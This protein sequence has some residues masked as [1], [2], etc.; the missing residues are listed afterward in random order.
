M[1]QLTDLHSIPYVAPR[2]IIPS[3]TNIFFRLKERKHFADLHTTSAFFPHTRSSRPGTQVCNVYLDS[4]LTD[5]CRQPGQGGDADTEP[6]DLR[7]ELLK[8]EA[9]HFA[10]KAGISQ[11]SPQEQPSLPE[12]V[13][14]RQLEGGGPGENDDENEDFEAKRRRV[15]EESRD[16]DADSDGDQSDSSEED[17]DDDEDETAELMRELAKIKKEKAE[18]REKEVCFTP[19]HILR[20][21]WLTDRTGARETSSGARRARS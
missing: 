1:L 10:K 21:W 14:K 12:P 7:A 11:D 15:L 16:I 13:P 19:L 20:G 17:S 4:S 3:K 18:Q 2:P 9:A 6:R 8:A 5:L